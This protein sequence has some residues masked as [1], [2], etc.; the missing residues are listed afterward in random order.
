MNHKF[1]AHVARAQARQTL[2]GRDRIDDAASHIGEPRPA[3]G[4]WV[5]APP[6]IAELM[7]ATRSQLSVDAKWFDLSTL[8]AMRD[9][10]K[11]QSAS[12]LIGRDLETY[13]RTVKASA[14]ISFTIHLVSRS[15]ARARGEL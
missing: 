7:D 9:D 11:K 6:S 12:S 2:A 5:G 3:P 14:S 10:L 1:R 4:R 13:D 15:Q 8:E